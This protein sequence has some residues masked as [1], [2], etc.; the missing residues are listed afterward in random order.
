MNVEEPNSLQ[1]VLVPLAKQYENMR[2]F[3]VKLVEIMKT[4]SIVDD[5]Y[6]KFVCDLTSALL[7]VIA[8][9]L[10]GPYMPLKLVM[11]RAL[12]MHMGEYINVTLRFE[13]QDRE[14]GTL[15]PGL[16]F[17]YS[18]TVYI[19][20]QAKS[21]LEG[22]RAQPSESNL[23]TVNMAKSVAIAFTEGL[24]LNDAAQS[25]VLN[26]FFLDLDAPLHDVVCQLFP[27]QYLVNGPS[28]DENYQVSPLTAKCFA[29]FLFA[30]CVA[31]A[32]VSDDAV[33]YLYHSGASQYGPFVW[34]ILVTSV[35]RLTAP[36]NNTFFPS[37]NMEE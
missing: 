36:D 33:S 12:F 6:I 35:G 25:E 18:N 28:Y 24:A 31:L 7:P 37:D 17:D 23:P 4:A 22:T 8:N 1:R 20:Q 34:E 11:Y 13:P 5:N 27:K 30:F 10:R 16:P 21:Q 29:G 32:T 14:T 9:Q 3:E 19:L 2:S 26:R 15:A